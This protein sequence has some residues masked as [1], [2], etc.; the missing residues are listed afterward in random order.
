MDT[1]HN[2]LIL[3]LKSVSKYYRTGRSFFSDGPGKVQALDDVSL[4]IRK[5]EMFGLVGRSGSG[6]TTIGRL[7]LKLESAEKGRILFLDSDLSRLKGKALR[8]FRRNMQM[9]CQDPYQS[10]NPYFSIYDIVSEPLV[11]HEPKNKS[12]HYERVSKVLSSVGLTPVREYMYRYPHQLSGGQ[13]QKAAIAR[14][15]IL[16]PVFI[17]ADEPTSMLDASVSMQIY[18]ILHHLKTT[19]G[20]TF[21]FITHDIAAARLLCDR[22]AVI[23]EGKVVETGECA[24]MIRNPESEYTR[25]LIDALPG[26]VSGK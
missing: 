9:I 11:I 19:L 3:E 6:K 25:E 8:R 17:V 20:T 18:S 12:E 16:N 23:H 7:V 26:F 13:K 21:L 22:I 14:A 2:S 24:E 15:M 4:E 5:G 1:D 10:L